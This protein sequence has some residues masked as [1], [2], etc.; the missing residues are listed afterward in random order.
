MNSVWNSRCLAPAS[1]SLTVLRR[2]RSVQATSIVFQFTLGSSGPFL[3][4][5]PALADCGMQCNADEDFVQR[6][7]QGVFAS[8]HTSDVLYVKAQARL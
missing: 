5:M 7:N 1:C 4:S 2:I 6:G 8:S 3:V